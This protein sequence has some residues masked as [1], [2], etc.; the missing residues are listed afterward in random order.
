MRSNTVRQAL[1]TVLII[2][3]SVT[4][5][6]SAVRYVALDG[7]GTDGL[8]WATAYKNIDAAIH[9]A[10]TAAGDDIR[11]KQGRYASGSTIYVDKAV[12]I[13]GGYSGAGD[14]RDWQGFETLIDGIN[15][16]SHCF[17]V[18][19]NATIDGF[20]LTKG[21][22]WG[23]SP[24][25]E[26]GGIYVHDCSATIGN[27]VFKRNVAEHMGGAI[28][29]DN[30]GNTSIGYCTFEENTAY[31]QGGA[32]LCY[33]TDATI[34]NCQFEGNE[35]GV[36]LNDG[37]GGAIYTSSCSPV[38]VDCTFSSNSA[39]YGA[40]ICNYM[41]SPDIARCTF[42]DCNATTIG[43][44]G[45]YNWGG[46][47]TVSDCLF[48]DN[49][50]THRG[51]AVFDKSTGKFID[52]IMWNNTSMTYGGAIHIDAPEQGAQSAA[53]FINCTIYGNSASQGGGLYSDNASATLVNCILWGDTTWDEEE[54]GE[55]C[56]RNAVYNLKTGASYCDIAGDTAYPGTGNLHVDPKFVNAPGGDFHLQ[57]SSPCIDHGTNSI[58]DLPANDYDGKTRTSDGNEDGLAVVDMGAYEAQGYTAT[59]HVHRG[60]ILEG[61]VYEN[62]SDTVPDYTFLMEF[63]T[64]DTI[65]HISFR[66]PA[67]NTFTIPNTE[68]TTSG[69]VET[70]HVVSGDVHTWQYWAKYDSAAGLNSYGDGTY[71]LTY[72]LV[73]GSKRETQVVYSGP[74]G[75]PIPQPT[76]KPNVTAPPYG[77]S[78]NV[79]I[80]LSWDACTDASANAVFV[81]IIDADTDRSVVGDTFA[82]TATTS[83]S[84][85]LA[86]GTY[87]VE[88]SFASLF[89]TGDSAGTPFEV[90]KGVMVGHQFEV[91]FVTVYRF[92]SP[93]N[94]V[95]FYTISVQE[96]EMLISDF[97]TIWTYEG[98]AYHTAGASGATGLLPVYR[99]WSGHSHFYTINEDEKN[100][101]VQDWANMWNFEGIAFYAYPEGQQPADSKP[102]YRFW[103]GASVSHFYT[104]SESERDMLI[105]DFPSIWTFEGVAFYA[106]E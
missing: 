46:A 34:Q 69:N 1:V 54:P 23:T 87:D 30:A 88:V 98:P 50:V 44:G 71:N 27:C 60:E 85:S 37:Y 73:G 82:K 15:V 3:L 103:N 48:Q 51:G 47:P 95:H 91:L 28:A 66:T 29:L 10:S 53:K 8:S 45:I 43:G 35:T 79:P 83:N 26:G 94:S 72:F 56:N 75:T 42:A 84:Y 2:L 104:I 68:H 101:L 4:T 12:K 9:A 32:I 92:W 16:V 22:G 14:T 90:G 41:A 106:Y 64:D 40:G 81:T 21:R 65:D 62:A 102:I 57:G 96:K 67:G 52:C 7:S 61:L 38:I 11:V 63:E 24:S 74:G 58:S 31:D 70:H 59:D 89:D 6:R 105:R 17:T 76:Q 77:A 97:P 18:S 93:V 13:Y 25:D 5:S 55:I 36:G 99:F 86:Q 20:T 33:R 100:M 80:S 39:Q 78:V 49:R 19:A